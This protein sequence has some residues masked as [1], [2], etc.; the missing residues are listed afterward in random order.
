LLPLATTGEK[1]SPIYPD[2][3]TLQEVGLKG[4]SVDLWLTVF[5]PA[6]VPADIKTKL[7]TAIKEAL[8]NP[9]LKAAFAKVGAEPRGTTP[10]E[11]AAFVKADFEK[12]EKVI[13]D[14]KIKV[15]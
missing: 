3:P 8:S 12:W 6:A 5:A 13:T 1:R 14:G 2:K 10:E 7:S 9:E 11:G 4:F 15:N